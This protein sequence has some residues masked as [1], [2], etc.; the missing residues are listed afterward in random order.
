MARRSMDFGCVPSTVKAPSN[1]VA[2]VP[3]FSR[4]ERATNRVVAA[5]WEASRK[6]KK[7]SPEESATTWLA[8]DSVAGTEPHALSEPSA[9]N[10]CELSHPAVIATTLLNPA[11][12]VACPLE[13]E[14][15][16]TTVPSAFNASE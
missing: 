16:A 7:A 14:P 9:F 11:G 1:T 8:V 12:T 3:T 13:L 6:T 5:S 10:A 15:H 2:P 4:H